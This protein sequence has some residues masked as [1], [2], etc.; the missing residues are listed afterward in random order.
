MSAIIIPSPLFKA[1][2]SKVLLSSDK[3]LLSA[4]IA[5]DEQ[6]R[7]P[8]INELSEKY[9]QAVINFEDKRF[10]FHPG[11]DP[12]A[13]TRAL[14]SNIKSG[15]IV[16]GGSTITMQVIRLSRK[17]KNRTIPEK[18]IEVFLSFGLEFKYSKKEIFL[19]YA[20]HAP[21]GG[22]IVGIEAA[23]RRY[24][25]RSASEL[26]WAESCLLAVLPN[27]PSLIHPGRNR[28]LLKSK[29]D[30]LL[31]DLK[32]N[33]IIS[34]LD[35]K[36]SI[37]EVLPDKPHAFPGMAAHLL[38]TLAAGKSYSYFYHST[39]DY[40]LQKK[41]G[42]II[43]N[44]AES[45]RIRGINNIAALVIDNV[46]S[47]VI[48]YFGNAEKDETSGG[49][50]IGQDVDIIQRMRSTGSIL[51]PFLYASMLNEGEIL[52]TTLVADI[53]SNYNGY[54]P[55][56]FDL[57]YRGAVPAY[58]SLYRSLNIPAVRMLK[59]F[60]IHRFYHALKM[61]GMTTLFRKADD[62]GLSLILGG[63]EGTLWEISGMYA[64]LAKA[65]EY[66][67]FSNIRV[68]KSTKIN[69]EKEFYYQPA[70]AYLTLK[71]MLE[72]T[73][74]G[75]EGYWKNFNSSKKV[76][77]KTGTSFGLRDA[78][79]VGCTAKYTVAV[80][81]GNA[82]GEGVTGLTGISAAA[83]VLFDIFNSLPASEWFSEPRF[84]MK[85]VHVCKKSGYI[86]TELCGKESIWVPINCN[87]SEICP[88]HKLVHLDISGRYR[89]NTECEQADNIIHKSWFSLPPVQEF[90]YK[91]FHPEYTALP[92]YRNDC[93]NN[94]TEESEKLMNLIYPT[95][96][97]TIYIP[98]D[99][100]GKLSS[101]VFRAV[102]RKPET[103]IY[104][105][106]DDE[107]LGNTDLFHEMTLNPEPGKHKII[108]IDEEG[109]R[110]ERGFEVLGRED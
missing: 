17:N 81:A 5:D 27:S 32:E 25:N 14:L 101:T 34:E 102:H 49:K 86:A 107:Y 60:G 51:K 7:F 15:K 108:L 92:D 13:F 80:W 67:K 4:V 16:S 52:P 63:A 104:W 2:Y 47:E 91:K 18:L 100:D 94:Q 31:K 40:N 35:Y 96:G 66:E 24:F 89:V 23:S 90:Y 64:N 42:N 10:Y 20:S 105:H 71:A 70:S 8:V 30:S 21:F 12:A 37:S 110:L 85:L 69:K 33:N 68:L 103:R 74:P 88:H 61:L 109:N 3:S 1:P 11:L 59:K 26:S 97:T 106:M 95:S 83:P 19:L 46:N 76:S 57:K 82:D 50:D 45:L 36:L 99:L 84:N 39:I 75:T 28:E 62:Y 53:P 72:V 93:K 98:V 44:N 43:T 78:W 87:F 77:W 65:A 6:W 58:E 73:R 38:N 55:E 79:A 22:N 41:L 48:A 29:R 54:M 56:N 9:V